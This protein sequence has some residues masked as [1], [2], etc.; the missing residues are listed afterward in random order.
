MAVFIGAIKSV[1]IEYVERE[2][3]GP[4]EPRAKVSLQ[5]IGQADEHALGDLLAEMK[6][7]RVKVSITYEQIAIEE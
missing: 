7:S 3:D 1:G 2:K 5:S 6:G 4:L